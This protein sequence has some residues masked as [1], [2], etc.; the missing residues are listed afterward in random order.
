MTIKVYKD[1][2]NKDLHNHLFSLIQSRNFGWHQ[3]KFVT[4]HSVKHKQDDTQFCHYLCDASSAPSNFLEEFNPLF[5]KLDVQILQRAK[6]N[7]TL[8]E[9][10]IRILGGFHHDYY[11]DAELKQ[12]LK[13]LKIALYY[14]NTTD[15]QTL[16]EE[17]KTIKKIDCEENSLVTFSNT[18]QHTANTHT[19]KKFRYVLNINYI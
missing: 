12:P 1:F 17:N 19:N 11:R 9:D 4:A 15:G 8:P 18:L 14:F 5:D 3:D 6:L 2:L 7:L 10:E 16:I 13:E